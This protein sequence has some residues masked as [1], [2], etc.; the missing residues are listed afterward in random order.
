MERHRYKIDQKHKVSSSSVN[1]VSMRQNLVKGFTRDPMISL[2]IA[3]G[4]TKSKETYYITSRNRKIDNVRNLNFMT[5]FLVFDF[6]R[7]FQL[8]KDLW[9]F[10]YSKF[11]MNLEYKFIF[12]KQYMVGFWISINS[13]FK[14]TW[15]HSSRSLKKK[16]VS[17]TLKT[18][19][20]ILRP[21]LCKWL[22]SFK[23]L[24]KT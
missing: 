12:L 16:F 10:S 11:E 9:R 20:S 7:Q 13:P 14:K 8:K 15:S 24:K 17:A 19:F 23:Y 1:G 4:F 21:R 6:L 3:M 18:R 22:P 5:F 2:A